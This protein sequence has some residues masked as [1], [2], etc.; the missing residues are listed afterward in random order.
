MQRAIKKNR[1]T[2]SGEDVAN[3]LERFGFKKSVAGDEFDRAVTAVKTAHDNMR[4]LFICGNVGCGKTQ[5]MKAIAQWNRAAVSRWV[6][7]K[8]QLRLSHIRNSP[9]FFYQS[10]VYLDDIGTEEKIRDYGNTIDVVGDFIQ[11]YHQM[12]K[13]MFFATTNLSSAKLNERY[14]SRVVDR[15]LDM[16]VVY[17]MKGES[18]RERIILK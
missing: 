10:N 6:Y 16:C 5:L 8:D 7:V 13:G 3:G 18:K 12:G 9:E 15:L 11:L 17:N 4:G 14:D 1:M 2:I